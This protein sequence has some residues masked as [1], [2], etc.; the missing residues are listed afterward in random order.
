MPSIMAKIK[1]CQYWQKAAYTKVVA[2]DTTTKGTDVFKAPK[3]ED[4]AITLW[5]E[6]CTKQN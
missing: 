1:L 4:L 6:A 3:S 2:V 5:K